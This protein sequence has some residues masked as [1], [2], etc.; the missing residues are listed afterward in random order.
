MAT[1][2][3]RNLPATNRHD[4]TCTCGHC[5]QPAPKPKPPRLE[6]LSDLSHKDKAWDEHR[7]WADKMQP[8]LEQ[9]GLARQAVR[10]R[11]CGQSLFYALMVNEQTAEITLKL[12]NA[13]LCHWRHCPICQWRRMLAN[14]ARLNVALPEILEQYPTARWAML[15]LTVRNPSISDLR[16]TLADMNRGWKRLIERKSWPAMGWIRATEVTRAEDGAAHPHFHALML[17]P[18]SYFSGQAYIPT[19]A[20]VQLWRQAMRLDYDPICDI[21]QVK[22]KPGREVLGSAA[23]AAM[24]DA[25]RGG[26]VREVLKYATKT[27]D[28]L[29]G[30]P[31]WLAEYV[32]QVHGLK[33]VASGGILK[34]ILKDRDDGREDLVHVGE[35]DDDGG[36]KGP[37]LRFDWR[38]KHKR[39]A[40]K[41]S[42]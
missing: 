25:V 11:D 23:E 28:L 42:V 37:S 18:A 22:A 19:R 5:A 29:S 17:V 10:V 15:T 21:R 8:V 16:Q 39:Y 30:G 3:V 13:D 40:R 1:A 35:G 32:G 41:R 33:F 2:T 9:A 38:T 6:Y 12:H 4:N 31:D 7:L 36:G 14:L 26:G 34:G 27:A 20:W 24:I